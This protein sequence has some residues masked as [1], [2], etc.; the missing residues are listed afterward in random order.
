MSAIAAFWRST[1]GKKV[2]M[3]V[4]GIIMVA[5]IIGHVAGNLQVFAGAERFNRYAAFLKGLGEL[6]WLA[7]LGLLVSVVLHF[8]AAYQLT[9]IARAARPADYAK[10]NPQVSTF[11]SRSMRWGGVLLLV[12]LVFHLA[13]FTLGWVDSTTFSH[14]DAYNN[15]MIGFSN[16]IY[17]AFYEL[18]MVALALHLFHGAWASVRTLGLSK[19]SQHPLH[20]RVA[21]VIAMA[22]WLGFA[23]IPLGVLLGLAKPATEPTATAAAP[24][25]SPVTP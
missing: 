15:V 7:R 20:R 14:T 13:Q 1:I 21:T 6:L 9:M 8:T 4:T 3:A 18:A 23:I 19:P 17:V 12:F 2:V 24:S 10:R 11:A 5:F 22:V 25:A 16:P